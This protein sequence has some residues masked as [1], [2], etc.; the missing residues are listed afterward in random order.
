VL[1]H[2]DAAWNII[3]ER[4][5][6]LDQACATLGQQPGL[7]TLAPLADK[8]HSLSQD[9]KTHGTTTAAPSSFTVDVQVPPRLRKGVLASAFNVSLPHMRIS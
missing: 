1:P 5:D 8:L 4:L 2:Q 7:V 9:I 6:A 3:H